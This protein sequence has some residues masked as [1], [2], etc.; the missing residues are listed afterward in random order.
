MLTAGGFADEMPKEVKRL[1]S[2]R[3]KKVAKAIKDIDAGYFRELNKLKK[4]YASQGNYIAAAYIETMQID[5]IDAQAE[6]MPPTGSTLPE[7]W[8][9]HCIET[10]P[11]A[12]SLFVKQANCVFDHGWL[13]YGDALIQRAREK[14]VHVILMF[15]QETYSEARKEGI[16]LAKDNSDVVVA[17]CWESPYYDQCKPNDL[18]QFAKKLKKEVP[19]IQFWGQFVEKPRGKFQTLPVPPEVDVIVVANYFAGNGARIEGKSDEALPGWKEKAQGRPVLLYWCAWAKK[20]PG[21]V[22]QCQPG[23]M[24]ACANAA[25]NHGLSGLILGHY[26]E[27]WEHSG[28]ESRPQLETEIARVALDFF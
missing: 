20:P 11:E 12:V 3:D 2:L 7:T 18:S 1:K 26:G 6:A 5:A 23:T 28:I 10:Q 19:G 27:R 17:M 16:A 9:G 14:G 25:R 8:F 22:M 15:R 24:K 4:K 13:E 21:L